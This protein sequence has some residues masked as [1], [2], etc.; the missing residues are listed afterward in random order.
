MKTPEINPLRFDVIAGPAAE[1]SPFSSESDSVIGRGQECHVPLVEESVSRRHAVIS[2]RGQWWIITD[3]GSRHGTHLNGVKLAVRQPAML[4]DGDVVAIGPWTFRATVGHPQSTYTVTIDDSTERSQR[5]ER[6]IGPR[7][8]RLAQHRL[9]LL[10]ECAAAITGAA[11]EHA[12]AE[13]ALK[14]ALAGGGFD[15]AALLRQHVGSDEIEILGY[16]CRDASTHADVTFSRSLLR[17]AASG[18]TVRLAAQ[19]T[20][21]NGGSI[22]EL[23]ITA[24]LCAPVMLSNSIAAYLYLDARGTQRVVAPDAAAFCQVIARLCGLALSNLKRVDLEQRQRHLEAEVQAAREA[25]L[26][27]LPPEQGTASCVKYAMRM[28]P[29]RFVAGD[30]FDVLALDEHR[31]AVSIGDVAGHGVGAAVLMAAAQSHLSG[32]L[33]KHED[34]AIAV[35]EVN[36]YLTARST[37][38]RFVSLW[39]AVLDSRD[40]S[41]TF[42]DAGHGHWLQKPERGPAKFIRSISGIPMGIESEYDYRS[43]HMILG[44]C[45]RLILYSDG[46]IEQTNGDGAQFGRERLMRVI[47]DDRTPAEDVSAVLD[48][49]TAFAGTPAFIDD[50][51]VASIAWNK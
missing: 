9:D 41:L 17:E 10:I 20:V 5:V 25:Q 46:A 51:T 13:A 33:R 28:R 15:R 21:A 29:G 36:R 2:R 26:L 1:L 31:A 40:R 12:L 6:I 35:N 19:T 32:A 8:A 14:S 23:G 18:E 50:T 49:V 48:A 42:V 37:P 45:D 47:A 30:L 7:T 44:E 24:A 43:E 39:V 11:N 27:I 38:N 34:P 22:A 16:Q 4:R 3:E